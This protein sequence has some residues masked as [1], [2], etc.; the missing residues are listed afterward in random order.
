[1]EKNNEN[2]KKKITKIIIKIFMAIIILFFLLYL[3]SNIIRK[4]NNSIPKPIIETNAT[5]NGTP[6]KV[7]K[8]LLITSYVHNNRA[9]TLFN[10]EKFKWYEPDEVADVKVIDVNPNYVKVQFISPSYPL[11]SYNRLNRTYNRLNISKYRRLNLRN[12]YPSID[13]EYTLKL[14]DNIE[15]EE[16]LVGSYLRMFFR[17]S[18]TDDKNYIITPKSLE[19]LELDTPS[20]KFKDDSSKNKKLIFRKNLNKNS[21]NYNT[22]TSYEYNVY[23]YSGAA[24]IYYG[25]SPKYS[26]T[27]P[28]ED[29]SLDDILSQANYDA[30]TNRITYTMYT[31]GTMEYKYPDHTIIKFNSTA[32]RGNTDMIIGPK[33]MTLKDIIDYQSQKQNSNN[34]ENQN[35]SQNENKNLSLN[36][37]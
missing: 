4:K 9:I 25:N 26:I 13:S 5:I 17:K 6:F 36:S 24:L 19:L 35:E 7:Y 29:F 23:T 20:L 22:N 31:D 10:H 11:T 37:N 16:L 2:K 30:I 34:K 18:D 3:Y 14:N 8:G 12:E 21:D 15:K 32:K 28:P 27:L 33:D 1:M